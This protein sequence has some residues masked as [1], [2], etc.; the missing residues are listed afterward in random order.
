MQPNNS[1]KKRIFR[2][3]PSHGRKSLGMEKDNRRS[4]YLTKRL[5]FGKKDK[6]VTLIQI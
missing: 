5:I 3:Y 2:E 6:L 4:T 1:M